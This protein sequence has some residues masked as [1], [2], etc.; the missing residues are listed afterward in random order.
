[1]TGDKLGPAYV[2]KMYNPK[3][4]V[5]AF[6]VI[7]NITRGPGKGGIRM[8][9]SVTEEEVGRL[10]RAMTLKNSMAD[11]PF[12]GGKSGIQFDPK[13]ADEKTKRE[14]VTWF[15][16]QLKMYAPEYYIAAP[17]INM[18]ETEMEWLVEGHGN[19]K[20]A[21]GKPVAMGGLPHELGSTGFGVAR[22]ARIALEH[23]GIDIKNA[24]IAI[25]GYGNV[26]T[27]AHKFLEEWGARI[28]AASDSKGVIVNREGLPY[29]KLLKTKEE[30]GTVTAYEDGETQDGTMI[31]SLDVDV[32]IPA[33][34]P[35]VIHEGNCVAD[36]KAKI[37]VEGANIS[38]TADCVDILQKRDI[39]VVPDF[40]ANA[41]GVISSYAEYMGY[42][43]KKAFELIEEKITKSTTEVLERAAQE[44]KSP[45]NIANQI[46]KERLD[47]ID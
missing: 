20:A 32:L 5:W 2:L 19:P 1:M 42:D 26:G 3:H 25:E 31:F 22:A 35:D 45:R 15:G 38:V 44:K 30:K 12:G 7:D 14:I 41:G 28:I 34:L 13:S 16:E 43:E 6:T 11:L 23:K 33:A 21:T 18:A 27:F 8:T 24:T 17:D 39:L 9:P 47:E 4:D 10:A 36:V 40:V 29:E 46:A 37:I